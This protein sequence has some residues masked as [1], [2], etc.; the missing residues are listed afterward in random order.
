MCVIYIYS[1]LYFFQFSLNRKCE[2]KSTIYEGNCKQKEKKR[3]ISVYVTSGV[4]YQGRRMMN[5]ETSPPPNAFV[6]YY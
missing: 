4:T 6:I 1:I 3:V 2:F 5:R